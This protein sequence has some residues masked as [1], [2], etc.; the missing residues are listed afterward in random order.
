MTDYGEHDEVHRIYQGD[1]VRAEMYNAEHTR[2]IEIILS[3]GLVAIMAFIIVVLAIEIFYRCCRGK[4]I[5]ITTAHIPL[6]ELTPFDGPDVV[7]TCENCSKACKLHPIQPESMYIGSNVTKIPRE[8][9]PKVQVGVYSVKLDGALEYYLGCAVRLDDWL[10]TPWHVISSHTT[11]AVLSNSNNGKPYA[12]KMAVKNFE[13]VEADLVSIRLSEADF[14][15]LGL[16]KAGIASITS[17]TPAVICNSS[18]EP[19]QAIGSLMNDPVV[20][21]GMLFRGSTERGFS[22]APYMIGKQIAGIHQAG[23]QNNYGFNASY[24]L[25]LLKRP[26]ETAEWLLKTRR[27]VG[28]IRY[29]RSK[30]DPRDA[31]VCIDGLYHLVNI[32]DIDMDVDKSVV[33]EP[34][35][36]RE[37][38]I[39][40]EVAISQTFPP[41]YQDEA[42]FIETL[43]NEATDAMHSKNLE[44]AEQ[45]SAIEAEMYM[46]AYHRN[47]EKLD[48]V[49]GLLTTIHRK[50]S[51]RFRNLQTLLAQTPRSEKELR[52]P[53]IEE[54]DLLK[55]DLSEINHLRTSV[56]VESSAVR[57]IPKNVKKAIVKK[58]NSDLLI[59]V[60][61]HGMKVEELITALVDAGMVERLAVKAATNAEAIH[62]DSTGVL[63]TPST[64]RLV[65]AISKP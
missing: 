37:P 51:E 3:V 50:V 36:E 45:C 35:K 55:K 28:G 23:G 13:F 2:E 65:A 64:S 20:F 25:T 29:E 9:A 1:R 26:E 46:N 22:G 31:I 53:M 15:K 21:G 7:C 59:Q 60:V 4:V 30:F 33:F 12:V 61:D 58:T 56:H 10:V 14:S 49:A 6:P 63:N 5:E 38:E 44:V 17:K 18:K 32:K 24:I 40:P 47:M 62:A 42:E 57:E 41:E 34:A 39:V 43:T 8:N 27:K 16:V 11:I 48:Q 52:K 54:S 19:Q